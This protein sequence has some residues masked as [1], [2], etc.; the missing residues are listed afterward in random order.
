VGVGGAG[1]W[2]AQPH[3]LG[4]ERPVPSDA[5]PIA[6]L[7]VR[8]RAVEHGT[9]DADTH[10]VAQADDVQDPPADP[11]EPAADDRAGTTGTEAHDPTDAAGT[12]ADQRAATV[13]PADDNRTGTTGTEAHDSAGAAQPPTGAPPDRDRRVG[14]PH[15]EG[16]TDNATATT[17]DAVRDTPALT[18][19]SDAHTLATVRNTRALAAVRHARTPVEVR[20]AKALGITRPP[21]ADTDT[22]DAT[23]ALEAPTGTV[24][25]DA[26][27]EADD[28]WRRTGD[29]HVAHLPGR[30]GRRPPHG[31]RRRGR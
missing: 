7:D 2:H 25:H 9:A 27:A 16:G 22:Y 8:D 4:L 11:A 21:G 14:H 13:G 12:E 15:S 6:V 1:R 18:G 29:H 28:R 5:E 30:D 17:T 10:A 31:E 24:C 26:R 19:L 3:A 23:G 20:D